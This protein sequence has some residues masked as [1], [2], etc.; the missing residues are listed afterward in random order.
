MAD[1][2]TLDGEPIAFTPGQSVLQAA[3]AAGVYIPHLCFHPEFKPHGSCKVCTVKAGGKMVS[4]CTHQPKAGDAIESETAEIND[5]RR[6]LLQML[7]VEGNHF[8]PGCEKSGNC[9]LQAL[10]YKVEMVSPHFPEFY[11]TRPLDAS[12]PDVLIDFNRCILCELCVRASRDIDHKNVF[13]LAGRGMREHIIVNS[14]SGKLGDTTFAATDKA[15]DVCPV[16]AILRK[17]TG[18]RVPIGARTYDAKPIDAHV[19][20]ATGKGS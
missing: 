10:A 11:P 5:A 8:C 1:Q 9:M 7:F 2:F 3:L 18:F 19:L 13:A 14:A 12:H 4:A 20:D 16:G 6:A 15:A 17:R